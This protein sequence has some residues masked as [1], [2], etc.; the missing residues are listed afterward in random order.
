MDGPERTHGR[1][2]EIFLAD[3]SDES[4]AELADLLPLLVAAG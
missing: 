1:A 2:W 4:D 3:P